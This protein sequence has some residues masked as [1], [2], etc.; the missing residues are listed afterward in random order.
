MQ[1]PTAIN[2]PRYLAFTVLERVA[3]GS[4]AA[5]HDQISLPLAGATLEQ[6]LLMRKDQATTYS[7]SLN[8]GLNFTFGS[9]FSNVVNPRFE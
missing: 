5:I 6:I 4:Y 8:L 7:F 1:P 3:G 9:M 2:D